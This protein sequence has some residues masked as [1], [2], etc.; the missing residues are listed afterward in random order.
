[1][2]AAHRP[3]TAPT[4]RSISPSSRMSTTPTDTV[5]IGAIC[6]A[7]FVRFAEVRKFE[8]ATAKYVQIS[9]R[10]MRTRSEPSSPSARR[11]T[12]ARGPRSGA[13]LSGAGGSSSTTASP[14]WRC[15]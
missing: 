4:D 8:L 5:P 2:I 6:S 12:H 15:S 1:M 3:L 7:R 13:S 9:A 14:A 11:L 10:T